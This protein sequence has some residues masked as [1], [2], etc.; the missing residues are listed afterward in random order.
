M[1][2]YVKMHEEAWTYQSYLSYIVFILQ[3]SMSGFLA[4]NGCAVEINVNPMIRRIS[5]R[6]R[7][8]WQTLTWSAATVTAL[9]Q[10]DSGSAWAGTWGL[11]K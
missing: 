5:L 8:P 4:Q 2:Q 7:V 3:K 1:L 10:L 11:P 9:A 6:V